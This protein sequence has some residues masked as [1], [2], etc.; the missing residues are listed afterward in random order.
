[1]PGSIRPSL[2]LIAAV[3]VLVAASRAARA[4]RT[5]ADKDVLAS[6]ALTA[7]RQD[8]PLATYTASFTRRVVYHPSRHRAELVLE[9]LR[10]STARGLQS[11]PGFIEAIEQEVA[12]PSIGAR[13]E[14]CTGTVTVD[15]TFRAA[16]YTEPQDTRSEATD[17]QDTPYR[18][19]ELVTDGEITAEKIGGGLGDFSMEGQIFLRDTDMFR[20]ETFQIH[21]WTTVEGNS[22][23]A[24]LAGAAE[25]LELLSVEREDVEGERCYRVRARRSGPEHD[26]SLGVL[27]NAE[28]GCRAQ[29][30][31]SI[32]PTTRWEAS[33][34]L[35]AHPDGLWLPTHVHTRQYVGP[36]G[37]AELSREELIDFSDI[38]VNADIPAC[39]FEAIPPKGS[40]ARE[41]ILRS[42][43]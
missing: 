4:G 42:D 39:V 21:Q 43:R 22:I 30:V 12:D 19:R 25:G 1:M 10:D 36:P 6:L 14:S 41:Q 38:H 32:G 20:T 26:R 23:G 13:E 17:G 9:R 31:T 15:G 24:F 40:A 5:Q 37:D 16:R 35:G 2:A 18:S 28:R 7:D 27:V 29:Q 33:I 8:E 3:T 34:V 11:P